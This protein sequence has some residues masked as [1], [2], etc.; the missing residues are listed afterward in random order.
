M[1]EKL[2]IGLDI[3]DTLV[4]FW[5]AYI[6]RFSPPTE[7][8]IIT[9]NVYKLRKDK[10]FWENLEKLRDIDFTPELY[11]TKRVNPK[12]WTKQ[13]LSDNGF[14]NSPVYQMYY[15][16]G[17][18]AT[19][20]KGRCDVF[21]D[22]SISNFIKMNMSGIPCLLMDTPF[23]Q[24]FGPVLRVYSLDKYEIEEAY[25]LGLEQGLFKHFK[26]YFG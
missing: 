18:K 24:N 15:Q 13:W 25:N 12:A 16:K 8:H 1:V 20:I 17:N 23:N 3:D 6:S 21:I 2:R 11:C 10:N 4:D 5:G 22:D 19:M 26:Q 14:Y 7:D 9:R